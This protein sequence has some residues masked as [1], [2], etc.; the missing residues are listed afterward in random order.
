MRRYDSRP[1]R[2]LNIAWVGDP[3]ANA[4]CISAGKRNA[5]QNQYWKYYEAPLM[6]VMVAGRLDR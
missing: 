3:A 5:K 1:E 6:L 4:N 2:S